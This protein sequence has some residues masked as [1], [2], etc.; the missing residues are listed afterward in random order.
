MRS[1][2]IAAAGAALTLTGAASAQNILDIDLAGWIADGGVG[3]VGNSFTTINL[4]VGAEILDI[5]YIDLTFETFGG[6]WN[7]E[8]VLSVNDSDDFIGYWDIT[9][10]DTPAAGGVFGPV[11][12]SF[13][14]ADEFG[15]GPFTLTTGEL[16]IETYALWTGTTDDYHEVLSGTLR[17]TWVPTPGAVAT[18]GLAGLVAARRRRA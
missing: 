10:N 1:L 8:F 17:V 4:P 9:I 2:I 12:D 11:S 13:A 18:F 6:S 15:G 7:D 3:N 14:N 5:E 16:F